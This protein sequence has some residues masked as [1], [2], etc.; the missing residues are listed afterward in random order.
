MSFEQK[1]LKYKSKYL[2]LKLQLNIYKESLQKGGSFYNNSDDFSQ[3]SNLISQYNSYLT[4]GKSASDKSAS[5]KS[6]S[7]KSASDKSASDKSASEKSASD[8]SKS[9][10]SKSENTESDKSK[11]ENTES[12]NTESENTESENTE[13]DELKSEN[14]ES[15]KSESENTESE[16]SESNKTASENTESKN[17]EEDVK[18]NDDKS[19]LE[20]TELSGGYNYSKVKSNK[21]YFFN[22]S[23]VNLDST[24][25][26]SDLSSLDTDSTDESDL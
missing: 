3:T 6:A 11:S 8:K 7:D 12:E 18:I 16:K 22:D 26:D 19:K 21:K 10:K 9:D 13:S 15:E 24:T 1:Y 20:D 14:T 17:T 25:T 2:A 23:D 4:G 5:D